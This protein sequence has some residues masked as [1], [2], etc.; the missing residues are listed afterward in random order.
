MAAYSVLFDVPDAI[1]SGLNAGTLERVG[2]VIRSTANK[3][4]V[5]WLRD[6]AS[7][8]AT[9]NSLPAPLKGVSQQIAGMSA[10]MVGGQVLNFGLTTV[11]LYAIMQKLTLLSNQIG[12]LEQTVQDEFKRERD[13]EFR[14]ALQ[15]A[16]DAFESDQSNY[17][18]NAARSAIDGLHTATDHFLRDF[19]DALNK[20]TPHRLQFATHYFLR[21]LYAETS[22][23]RCYV[24]AY[25]VE[26][27]RKRLEE[28][29]SRFENAA[30][31]LVTEW[32]GERPALFF[33]KD[34]P[35]ETLRRFFQ[36][37]HWLL[38]P[39]DMGAISPEAALFTT[40][41]R[42]RPDFWEQDIIQDEYANP[43]QQIARRPEKT[44]EH[45]L[46]ELN[47][48]VVEAEMIIENYQRL[49]G[50]ELEL[51]SM[52][53]MR[54]SFDEWQNQI[55]EAELQE[56]GFGIIVDEEALNVAIGRLAS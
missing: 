24:V 3:Q 14:T 10:G 46:D 26:T 30:S 25:D 36:V 39:D 42:V 53:L 48:A 41:N 31:R 9:A 47:N 28:D 6:T 34:V 1:L 19:D 43:L 5:T 37:Q 32:I 20:N 49:L 8:D 17:R 16:R 50:F 38:A 51:R 22:R 45:K 55:P 33:Y 56:H 7:I 23:I 29:R 21:A 11:S 2:G 52:R 54:L 4:V 18:D 44:L 35:D 12:Q 15:A 27:A 40:V 13:T